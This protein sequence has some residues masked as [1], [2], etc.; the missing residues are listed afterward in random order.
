MFGAGDV[1][2][3]YTID[4]YLG[5][6]S[7][8]EVY[9]VHHDDGP[10]PVALKVLHTRSSDQERVRERFAREFTIASM[11]HHPHIVGTYARGEIDPADLGYQNRSGATV[12]WMAMEY[13]DGMSAAGLIP[14]RTAEPDTTVVAAIG[15]QIA[16]ALDYAHSCEVLH[17]DV[18]PANIMVSA[19]PDHTRAVLTDFGIAQLLDDARPLARNG[20]VQ[21]SIA[22]AAPELLTAQ[23]LTPAT[24]LYAL[25]A[26]MFELLTGDPPYPRA[27]AFAITY[28]HLHDPVPSLTRARPW[29][30]SALN[31]VFTKALAKNPADRYETCSEFTDI[32]ERALRGV[33]VPEAPRPRRRLWR[34]QRIAGM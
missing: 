33:P 20:R 17:R 21:G 27:T 7:S 8:A 12:L 25:A 30:P 26:G 18:K 14:A 16:G 1:V 23:R 28:A 10:D 29:L 4:Q 9:R 15:S 19:G 24:D 5:S 3:G 2:A 32:V 6:G 13:V 11:L 31:S 22:Y 34:R